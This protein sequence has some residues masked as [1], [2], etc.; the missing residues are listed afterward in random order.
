[1]KIRTLEIIELNTYIQRFL[2]GD[3]ILNNVRVRGEI[4]NFKI[5]SSGNVY[6]TLKD[7]KSKINSI[8]FKSNYDKSLKLENGV[9]IVAEGYVSSYVRDGAYQLY[10]NKIEREGQ[11]NL[12]LEFIKL[13]EKLEKEGLFNPLFKKNIPKFPKTIGVVTSPTGAVIKDIINVVSR[14][15]PKV[16][17]KLYPAMVQGEN[18]AKTLIEGIEFLNSLGNI[19]V[20]IIGRGGGS[21]EELWSFNDENLARA[22]YDSN[23]PVVS[24]V[25][26]ETDFTICDFVSDLRA[27]TPSAAA[28]LVT[29]NLFDLHNNNRRMLSSISKAVSNKISIEKHM[30]KSSF[31]RYNMYMERRIL[32]DGHIQLDRM[33]DGLEKSINDSLNR[34]REQLNIF[35]SAMGAMNPFSVLD[36]GYSIAEKDGK[37]IKSISNVNIKDTIQLRLSDGNIDC[38][39]SDINE[40]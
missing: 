29:P 16:N 11:G 7:E 8:V 1:M 22:I 10:I 21:I 18:S 6:L 13:K 32:N 28:E 14:R 39:V 12:F 37:T 34:K 20:I 40:V 17:I 15:Y 24:A 38:I 19:D 3:P 36:R 5:H 25:G 27:P 23:V 35:A 4:S 30:L 26:H 9:K 2:N 31:D 33:R